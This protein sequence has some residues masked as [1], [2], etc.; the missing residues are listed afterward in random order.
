MSFFDLF[1]HKCK[2]C[3]KTD[4]LV[5]YVTDEAYRGHVYYY[6]HVACWKKVLES[7]RDY[8]NA[9][10]DFALEVSDS[11]REEETRQI[12][13]EERARKALERIN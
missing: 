10:V 3:G 6:Y 11:L 12:T 1:K 7:P 9:E 8:S 2:L 4:E 13:R 5:C